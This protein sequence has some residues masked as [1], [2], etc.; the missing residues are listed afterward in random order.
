MCIRDSVTRDFA[1]G[2]GF[3]AALG[4]GVAL[5]FGSARSRGTV[6]SAIARVASI[7]GSGAFASG[8]W[9][10]SSSS[11][12]APASSSRPAGSFTSRP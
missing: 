3:G 11:A 9:I 8:A 12:R 6:G 4:F 2:F 5:D 7:G 1:A 10:T